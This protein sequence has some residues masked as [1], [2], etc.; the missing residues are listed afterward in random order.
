M[1]SPLE[2][3]KRPKMELDA[4]DDDCFALCPTGTATLPRGTNRVEFFSHIDSYGGPSF[5]SSAVRT[6][7]ESKSI[8]WKPLI[9]PMKLQVCPRGPPIPLHPSRRSIHL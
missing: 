9:T 6:Y 7:W 1:S 5:F 8:A 4:P 3:I 2:S